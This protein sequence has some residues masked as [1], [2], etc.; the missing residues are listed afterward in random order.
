MQQRASERARAARLCLN[1]IS[2]PVYLRLSLS[3]SLSLSVH[4]SFR[5]LRYKRFMASIDDDDSA[6]DAILR[7]GTLL[8]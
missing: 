7:H 6:D 8:G 5:I 3:L 2:Q 1:L 4:V